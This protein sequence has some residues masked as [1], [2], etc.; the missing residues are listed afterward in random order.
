[1]CLGAVI[2]LFVR[3]ERWERLYAAPVALSSA[4]P[5]HGLGVG[6]SVRF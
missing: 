6:V 3:S 4:A 1:M 2:G 5:Q